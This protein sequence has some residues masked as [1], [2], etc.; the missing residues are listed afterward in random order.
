MD[1][2]T[3]W[4]PRIAALVAAV[5]LALVLPAAAWASPAPTALVAA[6]TLAKK[7]GR[8]AGAAGLVSLLCCLT[9]VGGIA[10]VV[11]MIVKRRR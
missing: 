7:G 2:L 4:S 1:T 6:D 11:V 10:L 3:R 5:A 8:L 9:V